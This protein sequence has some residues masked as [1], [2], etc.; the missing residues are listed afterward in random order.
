MENKFKILSIDGGGV[1]GVFVAKYLMKIEAELKQKGGENVS[2]R[3]H[4]DLITGSSTGALMAIA[5]SLGISAEEIYNLY[6]NNAKGIFGNKRNILSQFFSSSHSSTFLEKI[7]REKFSEHNGGEDPR[8]KDCK[9]HVCIPTYNL[10]TGETKLFSTGYSKSGNR[11]SEAPAYQIAMAAVAA[12]T[13]FNPYE[14]NYKDLEGNSKQISRIIDGGIIAKNPALIGFY[15]ATKEFNQ[16]LSNLQILSIGTGKKVLA[17]EKTNTQWGIHYWF[18]K[19]KRRR[20]FEVFTQAQSQQVI[21]QLNLMQKGILKGNSLVF[22]RVDTT[23]TMEDDIAFDE[24]NQK[25]IISFSNL[26]LVE[27]KKNGTIILSKHFQDSKNV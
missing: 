1:K 23:L 12:P 4:F 26:A 21:S 17:N 15:E 20:L 7:V 13:Y 6:I 10:A 9:P 22:D 11:D 18:L 27:F 2:I 8:L 5:I 16:P 19:N 3:N 24:F 25:K 14:G